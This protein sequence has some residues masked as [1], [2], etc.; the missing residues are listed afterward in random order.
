M[1]Y[2][3]AGEFLKRAEEIPVI[4]VRSPLEFEDGHIPRAINIPLFDNEERKVVGTLYKQQ[5]RDRAVLEGLELIGPKL[6]EKVKLLQKQIEGKKILIHCWRGGLRSNNMAWLF[7]TAGFDVTL[8]E[9]GYKAYRRYIR[10]R[11]A[12]KRKY[13]ILGGKTGS[14]K[15]KIL[16]ILKN[17]G[18]QVLDLEGIALHKGSAFGNLDLDEQPTNEQFENNL[19]D[20]WSK[21]N[22][23]EVIWVEDESRGIGKVSLP[24]V[25]FDYVR[26]YPVYFIDVPKEYRI[27]HLVDEY[28]VFSAE[29]LIA[30]INRISKRLGGLN[31][32][33]ATEAIY[34]KDFGTAADILL[35]YY[36]KAYLKGLA[37]RDQNKVFTIETESDN[38][39]T[40]ANLLCDIEN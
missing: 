23:N 25:L 3:E 29:S 30:G 19:Y 18:C 15:S 2:M 17:K 6:S 11:W 26:A 22:P 38:A 1:S 31:T 37:S 13:K 8:L 4:D 39:E 21:L 9:G 27:K 10:E 32:K 36:D 35:G 7:N 5:G 33:L 16:D 28:A 20:T 24:E 14:G 40:N 34:Q 12:E